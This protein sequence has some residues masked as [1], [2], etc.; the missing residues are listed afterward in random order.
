MPN[1]YGNRGEDDNQDMRAVEDTGIFAE[2][3]TSEFKL[4]KGCKIS[5]LSRFMESI[6][7]Y[8]KEELCGIDLGKIIHPD[9]HEFF[10]ERIRKVLVSD[11][12]STSYQVKLIRKDKSL[13]WIDIRYILIGDE[14]KSVVLI[15]LHDITKY[16]LIESN[17]REKEERYRV[18]LELLP[19]G[20]FLQV[21]GMM[22]YAN[23][24]TARM[25][26]Y[27]E[28]GEI[29]GK[30]LSDL[31]IPDKSCI[32]LYRNC[33]RYFY[34]K[35][36]L[37]ASRTRLVRTRDRQFIDIEIAL[38]TVKY[39]GESATLG[40]IRD[41]SDRARYEQLQVEVERKAKLLQEALE[42]DKLKTDFFANLSHEL[43]TPL[44]VML[45]VVQLQ[46]QMNFA[47]FEEAYAKHRKYTKVLRQNC[48]RFMRLLNNLLDITKI[49][50]GYFPLKLTNINIVALVEDIT[51]ST[52][53]YVNSKGLEIIFD[54][55]VEE[56][57]IAVDV[58]K[59]E[60]IIMNLLSNAVKFT[61]AGG[62]IAVTVIANNENVIISI[63]DS[64]VG[65]SE[66]KQKVVFDR[67]IQVDKSLTRQAGGSGIGLALVKSLVD[68]HNGNITLHSK[69][70]EG[71]EFIIE[72]PCIVTDNS[73][74]EKDEQTL[75]QSRIERVCIEFSDIYD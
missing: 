55:D 5:F 51:Q 70:R 40:V 35:G 25:F 48:Y 58:D 69:E 74:E 68:M 52:V 31:V 33:E 4:I 54:T 30:S 57:L 11:T 26:G 72:F 60:R 36:Y 46:E 13:S 7:G 3:I 22:A 29:I 21:K 9:Y 63:K 53:E 67:F 2:L 75:A 15:C 41:I 66:E 39:N 64:G 65:I 14:G 10:A 6:T 43:R 61:P 34:E 8:T 19:D 59:I 12:D 49:E 45:G 1:L 73:V 44:N 23:S 37:P 38:S 50:A 20:V 32:Q 62:R 16:K 27:S 47:N 56:K 24:A 71:S 17:L 28:P 42:Q 18:I